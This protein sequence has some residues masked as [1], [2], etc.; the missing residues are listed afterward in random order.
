MEQTIRR[1][2]Q[3]CVICLKIGTTYSPEYV[4][5]LYHAIRK[6]T[7]DDFLC[8]TDDPT[9]VD[10][11]VICYEM[12]PRESEGWWPTWSKIEIF[13]RNEIEKY[14]KKVYFDLDLVIQGDIKCILEHDADW[15]VIRSVWKGVKFRTLHLNE[16]QYNTSVMVWKD[17][18]WIYRRWESDWKN[19]V[20]NV[21]GTDKWYHRNNIVPTYLPKVFY[22]YREGS[23]P[24]HYWENNCQPHFE[25]QPDYAVCLFHQKPD[26]HE[27]DH[28]HVLYKTWNDTL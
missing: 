17:I 16:P 21:V 6:H 18:S 11:G 7:D 1:L 24:S 27:L 20:K 14:H 3:N 28:E 9:G 22:S 4:N 5:N 13:G 19:I 25:Y 15:A 8:F 26:V 12:K 10:P 23:K 2:S